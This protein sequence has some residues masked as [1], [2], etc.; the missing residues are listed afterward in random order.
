MTSIGNDVKKKC[1]FILLTTIRVVKAAE[2]SRLRWWSS[3]FQQADA[4]WAVFWHQRRLKQDV[5]TALTTSEEVKGGAA[6]AGRNSQVGGTAGYSH[7][8]T[9]S[10]QPT[11][12][13]QNRPDSALWSRQRQRNSTFSDTS[14][15]GNRNTA[16]I[17]SRY[18]GLCFCCNG[19]NTRSWWRRLKHFHQWCFS[20]NQHNHLQISA[21]E[22]Q[23]NH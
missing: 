21:Y 7:P 8:V 5:L 12:I 18:S 14:P 3:W 19:S 11:L 6:E 9:A 20:L 17:D 23:C 22:Q 13:G 15:T 2:N 16:L 1:V 10:F 4:G